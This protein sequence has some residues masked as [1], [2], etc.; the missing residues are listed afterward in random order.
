MAHFGNFSR[1]VLRTA[2]K[3]LKSPKM[4]PQCTNS[5]TI[6]SKASKKRCQV[7]LVAFQPPPNSVELFQRLHETFALC[8]PTLPS[9][10]LKP[11]PDTLR[12]EDLIKAS[13]AGSA[14]S[15]PGAGRRRPLGLQNLGGEMNPTNVNIFRQLKIFFDK[16]HRL[17]FSFALHDQCLSLL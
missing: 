5:L 6:A 7:F 2:Q 1:S 4:P 13:G 11:V 8:R 15:A 3:N 17:A 12:F 9:K 10:P 14:S 16:H